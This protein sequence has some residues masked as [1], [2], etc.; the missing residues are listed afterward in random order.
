MAFLDQEPAWLDHI[1]PEDLVHFYYT[2][3]MLIY[4]TPNMLNYLLKELENKAYGR[5]MRAIKSLAHLKAR[6]ALPAL[7]H[8]LENGV[9]LV[10][11]A[12]E[13]AIAMIEGD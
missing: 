10:R 7:K 4:Y 2:P 11:K 12:C 9:Y 8:H 3:N 1:S 6:E 5:R 13:E